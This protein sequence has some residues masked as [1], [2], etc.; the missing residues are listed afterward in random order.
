MGAAVG[1]A[2]GAA[3]EVA[4]GTVASAEADERPGE[5]EAPWLITARSS[6]ASWQLCPLAP[7]EALSPASNRRLADAD[8]DGT[9]ALAPQ[10]TVTE[11]PPATP[12][13]PRMDCSRDHRL[14]MA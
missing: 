8:A 9:Q 13:R 7:A 1:A 4:V 2:V 5:G 10:A 6:P 12:F 3:M 14:R 11:L